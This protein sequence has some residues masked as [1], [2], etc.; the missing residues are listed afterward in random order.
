MGAKRGPHGDY[1][2]L[3]NTVFM[4]FVMISPSP[5]VCTNTYRWQLRS[6]PQHVKGLTARNPAVRCCVVEG[7]FR[8]TVPIVAKLKQTVVGGSQASMVMSAEINKAAE[9][10]RHSVAS[11]ELPADQFNALVLLR[12]A[13]LNE[14]EE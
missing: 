8:I 3:L 10:G 9:F 5:L 11:T 12:A 14:Y 7:T 2:G 1:D 13:L 6:M 4:P